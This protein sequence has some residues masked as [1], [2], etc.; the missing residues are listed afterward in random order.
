MRSFCIFSAIL[1]HALSFAHFELLFSIILYTLL[2]AFF[3]P[4]CYTL[5]LAIFPPYC[6]TLLF[7][8]I[9][10]CILSAILTASFNRR[11]PLPHCPPIFKIHEPYDVFLLQLI[12]NYIHNDD[13]CTFAQDIHNENAHL[14]KISTMRT[15]ICPRYPP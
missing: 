15:H 8:G 10:I 14:P 13:R 7:I 4:Y 2:F 3:L 6:N 11:D 9:F 1:L 12:N 5:S